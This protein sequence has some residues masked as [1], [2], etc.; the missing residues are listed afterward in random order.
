MN[1]VVALATR[2]V[3]PAKPDEAAAVA[4]TGELRQWHPLALTFDGPGAD[5][6]DDPNPFLDYR[7]DVTF[8]GGGQA[9]TVPGFFAADGDAAE[10]GATAGSRW[11]VRFTPDR[12]GRFRWRA[13]FRRG[14]DV[15]VSD[16]PRAGRAVAFDGAQGHFTVEAP[17]AGDPR[18][19]GGLRYVGARYLRW[20]GSGE[21]HLKGGANSPENFLAYFEFDQ[22][23]ATHR[24]APHARDFR[25]EGRTWRD[26]R[27]RNVFGALD[28]LSGKG[29][30]AL[31]F[32]TMNVRG[33]GDDVWPFTDRDERD[34]Y[35]V[36][37]L[38]QWERVFSHMDERGIALHV[39]LQ[40]TE[41]DRLLDG[42][43]LGV[44]RRLYH[45]ELV[46]RFAHHLAVSW[47]LGEENGNTDAQRRAFAEH[48][49]AL[50]PYDHPVVVHTRPDRMERVYA[51]LL[52]LEA[53]T[54]AS[55]QSRRVPHDTRE[56]IRRSSE[57]GHP[58]VVSLDETGPSGRGVPPD[59]DEPTHDRT[60]IL[61]LWPHLMA[62]GAGVEWY[63]GYHHAHDD[64]DLEDFRSRDRM[65]DQT[66]HALGFFR[67]HL[68]FATMEPCDE[69]VEGGRAYCLGR[70]GDVYAL[71]LPAGGE[72][73]LD[74]GDEAGRFRVRWFD[75]RAGGPLRRGSVDAVAG[76]G[77][78]ALGSPPTASDRDWTALVRRIPPAGPDA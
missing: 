68:P 4:L 74:L 52:G 75:P 21:W 12:V 45:R 8:E 40:E 5:E 27:G 23:P 9:V 11:R 78:R 57:A 49:R 38:A 13:S 20:A 37:K 10:S 17:P 72:A 65:W 19:R 42:G 6:E 15:A 7:L 22:T 44:E 35:D 71:Y 51:P 46:A 18:A 43:D 55:L 73:S 28:Y 66:R 1:R 16:D 25:G 26:G 36:S 54:G 24:Y 29:V 32:L 34:R 62:G 59:A 56:W 31:Y 30:N 61:H 58:W 47:N 39:V 53:L 60:R 76:G 70:A 67:E 69:R 3:T 2:A 48:L 77:V 14:E 64:L 41:N 33:D 63:F 50:D